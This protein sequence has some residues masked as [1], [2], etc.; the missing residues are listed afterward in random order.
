MELS[1]NGDLNGDDSVKFKKIWFFGGD[2]KREDIDD[3]IDYYL[4]DDGKVKIVC[5]HGFSNWNNRWYEVCTIDGE[6]ET[7]VD[8]FDTLKA[9]KEYALTI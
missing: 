9:A 5:G 1:K 4:R 6:S 3:Y 2:S 8:S 7:S